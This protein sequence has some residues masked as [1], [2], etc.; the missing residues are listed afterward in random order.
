LTVSNQGRL[1]EIAGS[2]K[3]GVRNTS[4]RL[5]LLFGVEAGVD[6]FE[7]DGWVT[8]RLVLPCKEAVVACA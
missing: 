6:L 3:V 2:T 5:A 8:A 4:K 7:R 1:Q